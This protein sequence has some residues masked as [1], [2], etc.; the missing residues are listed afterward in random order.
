MVRAIQAQRANHCNQEIWNPLAT[1]IG[2]Q[3]GETTKTTPA[4]FTNAGCGIT[5]TSTPYGLRIGNTE[6]PTTLLSIARSR[7]EESTYDGF[8]RDDEGNIMVEFGLN[9]RPDD[10]ADCWLYVATYQLLGPERLAAQVSFRSRFSQCGPIRVAQPM[11][12]RTTPSATNGGM[13]H[14]FSATPSSTGLTPE[15]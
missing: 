8:A 1:H 5:S 11:P 9:S 14:S 4:G 15:S 10:G 3:P 7:L 2:A 6:I 12:F 13:R